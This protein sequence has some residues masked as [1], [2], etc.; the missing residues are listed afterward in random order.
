M[1]STSNK[2]SY[3]ILWKHF[4]VNL[5]GTFCTRTGVVLAGGRRS[6]SRR[7]CRN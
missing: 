7:W 4:W 5:K 6:R 1:V 3:L 2:V